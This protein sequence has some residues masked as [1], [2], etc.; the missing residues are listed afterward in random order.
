METSDPGWPQTGSTPRLQAWTQ[1]EVRQAIQQ[2]LRTPC[3]GARLEDEL[4]PEQSSPPEKPHPSVRKVKPSMRP[5]A[6][7]SSWPQALPTVAVLEA[8]TAPTDFPTAVECIR[9]GPN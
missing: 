9:A 8:A 4:P 6:P 5:L 7:K 3:A 2:S 1:Q